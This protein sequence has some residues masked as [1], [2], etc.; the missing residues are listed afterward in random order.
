MYKKKFAPSFCVVDL[1]RFAC[2][3]LPLKGINAQG[4]RGDTLHLHGPKAIDDLGQGAI[5]FPTD[6][7]IK[8]TDL[9]RFPKQNCYGN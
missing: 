1:L 3:S 6:V 5:W 9:L 7:W 4:V 2:V 8:T